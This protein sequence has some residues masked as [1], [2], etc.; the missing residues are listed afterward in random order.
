M[1]LSIQINLDN[2][3]TQSPVHVAHIL[4]GVAQAVANYPVD[5][6]PKIFP[7]SIRDLNGNK[8]GE[9]AVDEKNV[10]PGILQPKFWLI[11]QGSIGTPK[12]DIALFERDK[13]HAIDTARQMIKSLHAAG[14]Y[15]F[16]LGD[17]PDR[18]SSLP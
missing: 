14:Y 7:Q 13:T 17:E 1:H 3:A 2:D 4:A 9:W 16:T 18:A 6:L 15:M 8:I 11:A 12:L 10:A 5:P